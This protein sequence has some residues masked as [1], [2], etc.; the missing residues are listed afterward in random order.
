MVRSAVHQALHAKRVRRLISRKSA[1]RPDLSAT[2]PGAV[3]HERQ[4]FAPTV[5]SYC[6]PGTLPEVIVWD[7]Q[8]AF[9][10]R[11]L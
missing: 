8:S 7:A 11:A 3:A 10:P 2:N 4:T 9:F 5:L 1:C 6:L